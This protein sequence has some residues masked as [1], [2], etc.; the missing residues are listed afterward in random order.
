MCCVVGYDLTIIYSTMMMVLLLLY[1]PTKYTLLA[2]CDSDGGQICCTNHNERYR[3]RQVHA[4]A[5]PTQIAH[6]IRL[7]HSFIYVLCH[8]KNGSCVLYIF[9]E[10]NVQRF[11]IHTFSKLS[12]RYCLSRLFFSAYLLVLIFL[13]VVFVCDFFFLLMKG[14]ILCSLF[15]CC[16]RRFFLF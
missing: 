2:N 13:Y 8:E 9:Q 10:W 15:F 11:A 16:C 14:P 5:P 3:E 6:I 7:H 1:I 12:L 4:S